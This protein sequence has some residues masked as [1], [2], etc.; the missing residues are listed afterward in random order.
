MNSDWPLWTKV[1]LQEINQLTELFEKDEDANISY[2]EFYAFV[3]T[4]VDPKLLFQSDHGCITDLKYAFS[5]SDM[6][7]LRNKGY[8][9]L[10]DEVVHGDEQVSLW[11]RK[12]RE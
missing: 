10:T 8:K 11:F 9:M 12:Q 1:M 4:S 7:K 6:V 5:A 2:D 3:A